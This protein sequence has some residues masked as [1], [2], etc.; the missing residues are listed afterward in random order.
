[1]LEIKSIGSP[2]ITENKIFPTH[3]IKS[4]IL[5]SYFVSWKEKYQ[6]ASLTKMILTSR[7]LLKG[8]KAN[9]LQILLRKVILAWF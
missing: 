4:K 1:M 2:I 3:T 8:R 9:I 6:Q 5:G 7:N